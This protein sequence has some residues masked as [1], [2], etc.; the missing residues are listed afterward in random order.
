MTADSQPTWAV[1]NSR[2]FQLPSS[3]FHLP[4]ASLFLCSSCSRLGTPLSICINPHWATGR[5]LVGCYQFPAQGL[6]MHIWSLS[7]WDLEPA[8]CWCCV[9]CPAP[10][11]SCSPACALSV[12]PGSV[13]SV[14]S[15]VIRPPDPVGFGAIVCLWTACM[16]TRNDRN[17]THKQGSSS[18]SSMFCW[19]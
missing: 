11:S 10:A 8:A 7:V 18:S 13:T 15:S 2:S 16:H 9:R 14:I 12:L 19:G 5:W 3:T 17:G 1:I 4:P 6:W